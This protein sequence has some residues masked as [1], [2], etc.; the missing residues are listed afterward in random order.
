MVQSGVDVAEGSIDGAGTL[1]RRACVAVGDKSCQWAQ[2]TGSQLDQEH[3]KFEAQRRKAVAS[4]GAHACNQTFGAE[5]GQ[6]VAELA[7]TVVG[8]AELMAADDA[9]VQLAS[10]PVG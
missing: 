1:G 2:Q 6:V 5:F 4:A 9:G 3:A 7:Q 10:S 8:V